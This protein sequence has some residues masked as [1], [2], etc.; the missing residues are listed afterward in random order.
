M[1]VKAGLATSSG[2]RFQLSRFEGSDIRNDFMDTEFHD[3]LEGKLRV[4][5]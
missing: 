4:Q 2:E 3:G 5:C 1:H